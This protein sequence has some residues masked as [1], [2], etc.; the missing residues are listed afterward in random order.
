M[1]TLKIDPLFDFNSIKRERNIIIFGETHGFVKDEVKHIKYL[2]KL[3]EPK[4][5]LY[6]LLENKKLLILRDI[7][8]FLSN[9]DNKEFSLISKYGELRD[10]ITIA[11][12]NNI[13]IIGCDLKNMGRKNKFLIDKELS[14]KELKEEKEILDKRESHQIKIIKNQLNNYK[15]IFVIL[16]AWH[17]RKGSQIIK[18][19]KNGIVVFPTYNES[20]NFSPKD[21]KNFSK[22]VY[23]LVDINRYFR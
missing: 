11:K 23:N 3:F 6:E 16:G 4:L 7:D 5:I 14:K 10:V 19:F 2:V 22:V 12:K 8:K 21:I 17:I 1:S 18:N 15:N 20:S 9:S 13:P